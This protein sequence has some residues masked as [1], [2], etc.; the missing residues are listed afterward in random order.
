MSCLGVDNWVCRS[1]LLPTDVIAPN[2][3]PDKGPFSSP[4]HTPFHFNGFVMTA[5]AFKKSMFY[6]TTTIATL[7]V[8]AHAGPLA[9]DG[10]TSFDLGEES[11]G[12]TK[13]KLI[14]LQKDEDLWADMERKV[15]IVGGE[16][17][18][19]E[20][21]LEMFACPKGT[22]QHESVVMVNCKARFVHAALLSV[23]AKP[24]A[25]VNFDPYKAATG[26]VVDV[27]VLWKDENGKRKQVRAQEWVKDVTSGKTLEYDWVFG[28]SRFYK[29][30]DTGKESYLADHGDL[31]CVSN[32]QTAMLDLPIES[33][34]KNSDLRFVAN[35]EK[36][37]PLGTKVY[38]VL[39]PRL[40]EK[41]SPKN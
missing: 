12:K 36:V 14:R 4:P 24:G 30:E 13:P 33:S 39:K 35:T 1:Q 38:V 40:E 6:A 29:D 11:P 5:N 18:F 7:L 22:K 26:C 37:P 23:G 9:D 8:A 19:R 41:D 34:G 25:P 27:F 16:V 3:I 31:I 17:C 21:P 10:E 2:R 32:F 28:G 20:G 15:I